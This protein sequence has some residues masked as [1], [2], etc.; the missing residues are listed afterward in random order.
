MRRALAGLLLVILAAPSWAGPVRIFAVGHKQRLEDAV[1][2]QTF[3][4]KMAA[5][6]D[7]GFPSRSLFVQAGVDDVAS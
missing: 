2:Y 5:M 6:M 4:D 3:R 1:T 7:A